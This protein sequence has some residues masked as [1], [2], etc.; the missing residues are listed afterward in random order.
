MASNKSRYT[1]WLFRAYFKRMKRTIFSALI[2]GILVFFAIWGLINFYFVPLIFKTTENV[3]YAGSYTAQTIP[4][5]IIDQI[6]YGLTRIESDGTIKPAAAESYRVDKDRIYTFKIKKGQYFHNGEELT[7]SNLNI[8]FKDVQ[9]K[10]ID[11]YTVEYT[12]KNPYSPFLSSVSSPII[13]K[14]L[15]GLGKYKVREIDINGGFV[16]AITLEEKNNKKNK[17]K[18]FFYPSQRALKIAFM[19]GE[20]DIAYNLNSTKVDETDIA[21]WRNVTSSKHSDFSSLVVIFYNNADS[22]LSNKKIRQSLNYALPDNLPFGQRASGPISP[23][24][25]YYNVPQSYKTSNIE[26]SKELLSSID[27]EIATLVIQTPEEFLESAE[28][29]HKEWKKIGIKTEIK[30]V[31]NVPTNFQLFVYRVTLPSDPDQY[32]LWHSGQPSNIIHYKNLRID[33]LL[34]DGRSITDIVKRKEIYA[35]F[36]KYLVDDAPAAFYYY[37]TVY[38]LF[39]N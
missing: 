12:L 29:L 28:Y 23:N 31:D 34:E 37:P 7:A 11:T 4:D 18:I 5:E 20:V 21:K 16:R 13:T 36:Q 19:L 6:S 2:L 8:D 26:L 30:T 10:I 22:V 33:K 38:T 27:D 17:R 14:D 1:L 3:G 39:K 15:S 25:K 9:K 35:D 24:S 32:I